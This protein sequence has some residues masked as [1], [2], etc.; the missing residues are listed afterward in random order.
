MLA[1]ISHLWE[2]PLPAESWTLS[3]GQG[4]ES[5]TGLRITQLAKLFSRIETSYRFATHINSCQKNLVLKAIETSI[6]K[7][8][9]VQLSNAYRAIALGRL[10]S[11]IFF[12][13]RILLQEPTIYDNPDKYES[14]FNLLDH[15]LIKYNQKT[16]YG[17]PDYEVV[18]Q[19][20]AM[21][22]P[23]LDHASHKP[24]IN[25]IRKSRLDQKFSYISTHMHC[26]TC[27]SQY[28]WILIDFYKMAGRYTLLFE[29]I[30]TGIRD[31]MELMVSGLH[32]R[33][34]NRWVSNSCDFRSTGL[35]NC[36]FRSE[37]LNKVYPQD[38]QAEICNSLGDSPCAIT[39]CE[40]QA[41]MKSLPDN[42]HC[43][44]F[45]EESQ[46]PPYIAQKEVRQ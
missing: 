34:T 10:V 1:A 25:R 24:N 4:Y 23:L 16:N 33:V 42:C 27:S 38:K 30:K 17:Y 9:F 26:G 43:E 13:S 18:R 29:D 41:H 22:V 37:Y 3:N 2:K 14:L 6:D 46:C 28:A 21:S 12:L 31:S 19:M 8:G 11:K 39:Y 44:K 45:P 32:Q 35:L 20:T 5:Y 7:P 40:I 36:R 15:W